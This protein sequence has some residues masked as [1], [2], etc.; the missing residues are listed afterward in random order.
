[1]RPN[2]R[3]AAAENGGAARCRVLA[4]AYAGEAKEFGHHHA[5]SGWVPRPVVLWKR[6][7]GGAP[8]WRS[9]RHCPKALK[10]AASNGNPR[11]AVHQN[12]KVKALFSPQPVNDSVDNRV[13]ISPEPHRAWL[14]LGCLAN[15]QAE[16][17]FGF[18]RIQPTSKLDPTSRRPRQPQTY[19]QR[20]WL[21]QHLSL[22]MRANMVVELTS[23][24]LCN[25]P[26]FN[27]PRSSEHAPSR[28]R[29]SFKLR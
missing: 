4:I 12:A 14:P 18:C 22:R 8:S 2:H 15:E 3:E 25:C 13:G 11:C 7:R 5:A 23:C 20:P 27:R 10:G 16:L 1:M 19:R 28:H 24:A 26:A 21:M 29:P 9:A 17:Q 6:R